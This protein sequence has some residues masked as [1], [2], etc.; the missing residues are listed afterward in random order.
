MEGFSWVMLICFARSHT[1]PFNSCVALQLVLICI[2][3]EAL[4]LSEVILVNVARTGLFM[5][6]KSK[7]C[8]NFKW[9]CD[10]PDR[11]L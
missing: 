9:L 7:Q 10:L 4:V 11:V 6:S 3:A 1:V 8:F 5:N 2:A